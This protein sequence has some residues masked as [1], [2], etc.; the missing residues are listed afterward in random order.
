MDGTVPSCLFR[1]WL[2]EHQLFKVEPRLQVFLQTFIALRTI[3][4]HGYLVAPI[5]EIIWAHPVR[6]LLLFL[7]TP[8]HIT[9]RCLFEKLLKLA[10]FHVF[11]KLDLSSTVITPF[12][13]YVENFT[14]RTAPHHLFWLNHGL[15]KSSRFLVVGFW[16]SNTKIWYG[17]WGFR[18]HL[19]WL[20][21]PL[22]L[23][24]NLMLLSD[25]LW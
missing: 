10:A 16:L 20:M 13:H 18:L 24:K 22:D 1:L 4:R 12:F 23:V 8:D 25:N 11:K 21:L 14:V 7:S 3:L 2:T 6:L 19:L 17:I 15:I 5:L 9:Q